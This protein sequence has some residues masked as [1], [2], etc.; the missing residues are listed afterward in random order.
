MSDVAI[1]E[2]ETYPVNIIDSF[3]LSNRIQVCWN[4]EIE[5]SLIRHLWISE[6]AVQDLKLGNRFAFIFIQPF[7]LF[8]DRL[9]RER[10][11]QQ[12]V[13]LS[14]SNAGRT[15]AVYRW[16]ASRIPDAQQKHASPNPSPNLID[17]HKERAPWT[18]E[19]SAGDR[20]YLDDYRAKF[21]ETYGVEATPE[22]CPFR[23]LSVEREDDAPLMY[24]SIEYA[25][26]VLGTMQFRKPPTWGMVH[27]VPQVEVDRRNAPFRH[28]Y[29]NPSDAA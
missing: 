13:R 21:Y 16:N 3:V 19:I 7:I 27:V 24:L 11:H 8:N 12:E 2:M 28:L 29:P 1:I 5:K 20:A 6:D 23:I 10:I 26:W 14:R 15:A 22:E 17:K 9:L 4:P 25:G 18:E